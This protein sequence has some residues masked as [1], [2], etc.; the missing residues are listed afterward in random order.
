MSATAIPLVPEA[1]YELNQRR[2]KSNVK[3]LFEILDS[4]RDP[5]IPVLSIWDLGILQDV[6]EEDGGLVRV[7]ITPTYS[8]CPA[9]GQI[10]E[11]VEAALQSAGFEQVVIEQR[12]SPAWTTDWLDAEAKARLVG[13]GV[14]APGKA[15]CPQCGSEDVEVVSEFAST[16]CKA[17]LRCKSCLEPFDQF[18]RF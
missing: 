13:Y 15:K 11:D 12:L 18:K 2:A 3:H 14:A 6:T 17:L 7:V 8:G 16:S 5:E 4:V 1:R 9:M 10:T